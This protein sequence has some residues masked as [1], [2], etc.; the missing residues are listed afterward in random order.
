MEQNLL[1]TILIVALVVCAAFTG[2]A[3][4]AY[5]L[6]ID[7]AMQIMDSITE[8]IKE[9]I[10][11]DLGAMDLKTIASGASLTAA[12]GT[13]IGWITSNKNKLLAQKQAFTEQ[14]NN[15]DL[16]NQIKGVT[17]TKTE[18]ETQIAEITNLKD[19]A[20]KAAEDAKTEAETLKKQLETQVQQT[21][22]ASQMNTNTIQN[23][24]KNS[25]GDWWTD[26]VTKEKF[27]LLSL[28]TEKVI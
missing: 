4:C 2:L 22:T 26:P 7:F 25:G 14:L 11:A 16:V 1:K 12:V 9:M 19:S 27:K 23:L 28:V 6:K 8:P 20:V 18:L 21:T 13:G 5:V 24:W 15:S 3:L 10:P 17:D